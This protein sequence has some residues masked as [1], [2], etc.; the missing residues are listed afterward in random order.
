MRDQVV[1]IMSSVFGVESAEIAGG[2]VFGRFEKWDSL[3]H[4]ALVLALEEEFGVV[5]SDEEIPDMMSL[6]LVVEILE[7]KSALIHRATPDQQPD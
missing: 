7:N 3:R 4:M 2:V 1:R 6:D 5:F